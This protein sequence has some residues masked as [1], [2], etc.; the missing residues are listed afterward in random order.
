MSNPFLGEIRMF[1][2]TFAPKGW[3]FCDGQI[4]SIQQNTALF[5]LLGT[6]YG[7]NG[8]TTFS[9][10]D[11]RGRSPLH[12]GQG[13]GLS[14]YSLGQ[15]AGEENVTLIS[16][17]MP[18]HNHLANARSSE[19]DSLEPNSDGGFAT[20][21]DAIYSGLPEVDTNGAIKGLMSPFALTFTG[22]N[23]PHQ[24]MPPYTVINYSIAIQ[25]VFPSRN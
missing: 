6:T 17:E 10:P 18:S 4:L 22:Q 16:T 20:T 7:G 19:A 14:D 3:A 23:V 8:T 5:S 1:G 11:L 15:V 24:N 21:P 13:P 25:G 9:L 2:F 12:F